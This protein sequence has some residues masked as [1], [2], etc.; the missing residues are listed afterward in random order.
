[1]FTVNH[2]THI[3]GNL[4]CMDSLASGTIQC[5]YTML[6]CDGAMLLLVQPYPSCTVVSKGN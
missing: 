3:Q 5:C 4:D 2:R 6:Y 1:M